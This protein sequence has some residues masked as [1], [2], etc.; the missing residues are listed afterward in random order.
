ME[1]SCSRICADWGVDYDK[2]KI[3]KEHMKTSWRHYDDCLMEN[4]REMSGDEARTSIV[5]AWT[6]KARGHSQDLCHTMIKNILYIYDDENHRINAFSIL[7]RIAF[8]AF[9][10]SDMDDMMKKFFSHGKKLIIMEIYVNERKRRDIYFAPN[11]FASFSS[12]NSWS[13]D[14]YKSTKEE[15]ENEPEKEKSISKPVY[16][17]DRAGKG[18]DRYD[19]LFSEFGW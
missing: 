8:P 6:N 2:V 13:D 18:R 19:D 14:Q 3:Y 1:M 4:I 9:Y 5:E 10:D 7:V 17:R 16:R 12:N 15:K 11:K